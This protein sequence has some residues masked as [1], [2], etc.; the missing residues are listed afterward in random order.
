MSMI[1]I[2][3]IYHCRETEFYQILLNPCVDACYDIAIIH[4][5][6]QIKLGRSEFRSTALESALEKA[7]LEI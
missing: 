7:L 2:R 4:L 5:K 6:F 3:Q 1:L